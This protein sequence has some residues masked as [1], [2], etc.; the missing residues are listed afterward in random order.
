MSDST[1]ELQGHWFNK[2]PPMLCM[3][4]IAFP[5]LFKMLAPCNMGI[6]S[7]IFHFPDKIINLQFWSLSTR[8]RRQ[9]DWWLL[10]PDSHW[11]LFYT[12]AVQVRTWLN[13]HFVFQSGRE[14]QL[15]VQ[16]FLLPLNKE[17]PQAAGNQRRVWR[18]FFLAKLQDIWMFSSSFI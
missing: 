16:S 7:Q 1:A 18:H 5:L 14:T 9:S 4:T 10:T 17:D 11:L 3:F 6:F 8:T 15:N 13:Y 12:A 2:R